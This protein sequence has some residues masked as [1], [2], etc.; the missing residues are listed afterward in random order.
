MRRGQQR[1]RC[2]SLGFSSSLLRDLVCAELKLEV[3]RHQRFEAARALV[4]HGDIR[5]QAVQAGLQRRAF[6]LQTPAAT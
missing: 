5:G 4:L 2:L 6:P 1:G 3:L